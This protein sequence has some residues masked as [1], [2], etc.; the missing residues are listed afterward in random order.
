MPTVQ[1]PPPPP[2]PPSSALPQ[3]NPATAVTVNAS[4]ALK[5]GLA[6]VRPGQ[7]L[8][9]TQVPLPPQAVQ[10]LP[11]GQVQVQTTLG[12]ITLQTALPIPNSAVLTLTLTTLNPPSFLITELNGKPVPAAQ[13][14]LNTGNNLAQAAKTDAAPPPPPLTQGARLNAT[15]VRP[16]TVVPQA[17]TPTVPQAQTPVQTAPQAAPQAQVSTPAPT[18]AAT[19]SLPATG[20]PAAST[21]TPVSPPSS[22]PQPATQTTVQT[23]AQAP[24]VL[25]TGTRFNVSIVRIDAPSAALTTPTPTSGGLAQGAGLTGTITGTTPGGQPI[26]QTPHA[27]IA[28]NTTT[29]VEVGAKVVLKVETTPI[30][31]STPD[32]AKLGRTSPADALVQARAWSDLDEAMKSLALADPARF[33][34]VAQHALPQPG[35]KLSAQMLFFL[36][37]LK[38]GDI[39]AWLGDN[40]TR[41]LARDRPG[42]MNRLSGDF[43]IMSKMADEP[44]SAD[45]RLALVPLWGGGEIEQLRMYYRGRG[46]EDGED[47]GDEGTRFVLDVTLSNIGHVQIDGLVKADNQKLDLIIRSE[48]PLPDTWRADIAEIF[49]TAQQLTGLG[50]GMAFQAAPGNFVEFPAIDPAAPH[51]GLFA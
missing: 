27:T 39:K 30:V 12:P 38:G 51:P 33:Q 34:Q 17:P 50:G 20:A 7:S 43:Q 22:A 3:P 42:L 41:I 37:A 49:T 21:P 24:T 32:A 44:H 29:S 10:A 35:A 26:V 31:P 36:S 19:P 11:A 8:Q 9:A 28:L 23:P 4:E 14:A 45:W 1:P 2:P 13:A 15:L 16:A 25:P 47:G 40:A 48:D 18:A 46:E 5:A 6:Q